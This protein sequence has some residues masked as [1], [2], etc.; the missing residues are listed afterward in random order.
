VAAGLLD[1]CLLGVKRKQRGYR[2]NVAFDPEPKSSLLAYI[3][4]LLG[5]VRRE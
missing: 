3:K 2:Q 4:G 1:V 5:C